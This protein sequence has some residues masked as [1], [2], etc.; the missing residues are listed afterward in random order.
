M[1]RLTLREE[2]GNQTDSDPRLLNLRPDLVGWCT[3]KSHMKEQR[4]Y[5]RGQVV[6]FQNCG[7]TPALCNSRSVSSRPYVKRNPD[8]LGQ[9]AVFSIHTL[10]IERSRFSSQTA[11]ESRTNT[12]MILYVFLSL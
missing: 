6:C 8:A 5:N 1:V 9:V 4:T 2:D 3:I 7:R 11:R 10:G 12:S